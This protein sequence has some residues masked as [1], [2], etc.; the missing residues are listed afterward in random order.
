MSVVSPIEVGKHFPNALSGSQHVSLLNEADQLVARFV[1]RSYK[2]DEAI[3]AVD[4][5]LKRLSSLKDQHVSLTREGLCR[6][7]RLNIEVIQEKVIHHLV[8]LLHLSYLASDVENNQSA[9]FVSLEKNLSSAIG[10]SLRSSISYELLVSLLN[11]YQNVLERLWLLPHLS[12]DRNSYA[13]IVELNGPRMT[14]DAEEWLQIL[15]KEGVKDK[16]IESGLKSIQGTLQRIISCPPVIVERIARLRLLLNSIFLSNFVGNICEEVGDIQR[17]IDHYLENLRLLTSFKAD[18]AIQEKALKE[19]ECK[20]LNHLGTAY[21]FLGQYQKAIEYC[22]K[23]LEISRVIQDQANEGIA[24]GKIGHIYDALGDHY[25]AIEYHKK[26]LQIAQAIEDP[27]LE[28]EAYRGL[29]NPY[30]FLGETHKA[31]ECYEKHLQIVQAFDQAMEGVAYG[32]LGNVYYLLGEYRRAIEYHEKALQI[33]QAFK[34][35]DGEGKAYGGLG[36]AYHSLGEANKAIEYHKKHLHIAKASQNRTVEGRIYGS[37]GTVYRSLKE[38]DKAIECHKKDLEIAQ[39]LRDKAG[40][41]RAYGNLGNIYGRLEQYHRAIECHKKHLQIAKDLKDCSGKGTAYLNLGNVYSILEKYRKAIEYQEKSLQITQALG[42][43]LG[44]ATAFNN[45]G[46]TYEAFNDFQKSEE[47]FRKSINIHSNLQHRLGDNHQWKISIFDEQSKPYFRLEQVFLKQ[48]K[49]IE[50]LE[51]SNSRRSRALVSVLS[52]RLTPHEDKSLPCTLLT[53]QE[54]QLLAQK[55][56]TTFVIYSLFSAGKRSE[57]TSV[58][59][60]PSKGEI[61]RQSLLFHILPDDTKDP[62]KIFQTFPYVPVRPQRGQSLDAAFNKKLSQWYESLIAPIELY[63]PQDPLQTLTIV[64]DEFLSQIPFA[65]FRDKE[66]RY[67]IEKHPIAIAPSIK[68]LQ[69]LDQYPQVFS[70]ISLVIGNPTTPNPKDLCTG[71]KNDL[72]KKTR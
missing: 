15:A 2:V 63:L 67:L 22:E 56:K 41:G 45:L 59:I 46:C 7:L 31:I 11:L 62:S 50:A 52:K 29:G 71:Q 25:K 8:P 43:P 18:N 20:I 17:A 10:S 24:Y 21:Y 68:V 12:E 42:H 28:A 13:I 53:L 32:N 44:E 35:H 64:P 1:S 38:Y 19:A 4:R 57:D 26:S 34:N 9:Q 72:M 33:A 3:P 69:L 48:N 30:L 36:N 55:L 54:M 47:N 61:T 65:A 70:N 23:Y 60:I 14:K 5:L 66:G 58:W 39:D 27:A 37:L 40:E 6:L 49:I 51:I 16:K